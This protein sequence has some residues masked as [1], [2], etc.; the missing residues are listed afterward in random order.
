MSPRRSS[1]SKVTLTRAGARERPEV[2]RV[3]KTRRSARP[4]SG[5]YHTRAPPVASV[6]GCETRSGGSLRFRG[7]TQQPA[8]W[9]H[10]LTK[11]VVRMRTVAARAEVLCAGGPGRYRRSVAGRAPFVSVSGRWTGGS[12]RGGG[13]T[14]S[15]G[16]PESSPSARRYASIAGR[17]AAS[18]FRAKPRDNHPRSFTTSR[19]CEGGR[20]SRRIAGG[21][22]STC[23][24]F[25]RRPSLRPP[26]RPPRARSGPTSR[27]SERSSGPSHR[28]S[29]GC[30]REPRNGSR[31][32]GA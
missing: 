10:D 8:R 1:T 29:R 12:G 13:S 24:W 4:G 16:S 3:G 30:C 6:A 11:R 19:R 26:R 23:G 15:G 31:G 28:A 7:P 22:G 14:G 27:G 5:R 32:S 25:M 20:G 17:A 2:P 21:S 9:C 18:A